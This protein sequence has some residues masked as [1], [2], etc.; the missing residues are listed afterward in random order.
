MASDPTILNEQKRYDSNTCWL[1]RFA[2]RFNGDF[3]RLI[4]RVGLGGMMMYHG[5]SKCIMLFKGE[6]ASFP[7]PIHIGTFA[8][9]LL[10][11]CAEAGCSLLII[12]GL[13]TRLACLPLIFNMCVAWFLV[14]GLSG[15][16][17][18]ELA[19]LYLLCYISL[20]YIGPGKFSIDHLI[21]SLS[22]S[23]R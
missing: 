20:L 4:F 11:A 14:L 15:W 16:A 10:S 2:M 5:V 21:K 17:N 18:Q 19:A 22:C 13:L 8:S 3:G 1:A 12:V 9:L 7:D 23:K 6:W